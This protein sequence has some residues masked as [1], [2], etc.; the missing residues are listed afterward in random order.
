MP[1][2]FG[3]CIISFRS[4][5]VRMHCT[6]ADVPWLVTTYCCLAAAPGVLPVLLDGKEWLCT[7]LQ[8]SASV[9]KSALIRAF[10]VWLLVSEKS[11]VEAAIRW[12]ENCVPREHRT[13]SPVSVREQRTLL[14]TLSRQRVVEWSPAKASHEVLDVRCCRRHRCFGR[15]PSTS[16]QPCPVVPSTILYIACSCVGVTTDQ[17]HSV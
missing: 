6:A 2:R 9:W 16:P 1:L 12:A 4:Y 15:R 11:S 17:G 8:M 10:Y 7:S 14:G 5:W 3:L 13:S